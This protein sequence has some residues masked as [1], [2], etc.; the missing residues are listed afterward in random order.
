MGRPVSHL[1]NSGVIDGAAMTE[2]SHDALAPHVV[3]VGGG[4]GGL[5]AARRAARAPVQVTLID[6]TNHHL[7]QPLLYQVAMA[8]L[9]PADIAEPIRSLV[10]KERN[11]RVL[12]AEVVAVDLDQRSLVLEGGEQI[13]YDYLVIAAGAE[14][15]YFGH[16]QEWL[17]HALPLKTIE[18][19][20]EVRRRVLLAFE[21]AEREPAA[22][23][24]R[25]LLTF[26]VIGAGP[27]G[28][29]IAGALAELAR[30]VLSDDFR[31]IEPRA[32]RIVLVEALDKVLPSGF[33]MEMSREAHVQLRELGVEVRLGEMV[34]NID[35]RG[36]RLGDDVIEAATVLWTAGVRAAP[37]TATLGVELDKMGRILVR[38]DCSIPGHAEA[39]A[40]GDLACLRA[41]ESGE[42]LS[43]L[44]AV[45]LQEGRY[46]GDA[47]AARVNRKSIEPF[48]YRDRGIMATIGRSRAV[49]QIR[50]RKLAGFL[51]WLVWI[52]VHVVYLIGFRNRLSVLLNWVYGYVTYRRGARIITS[53]RRAGTAAADITQR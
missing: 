33:A 6:R 26:V 48:R 42:P 41:G 15:N 37:L 22:D 7:F 32:A 51:A 11:V 29:E 30:F 52:V 21:A 35:A 38:E 10:R 1:D 8:G 44:A 43:G 47:I 13:H 16:E 3:V 28:V 2:R 17:P 40:I 25:R 9:S 46:V 23:L 4:F 19:A 31:L 45:A 36:V 5:W 24:R 49:A 20:L 34:Q 14:T 50:D 39:F 18:D 12:L 53:P 27:T